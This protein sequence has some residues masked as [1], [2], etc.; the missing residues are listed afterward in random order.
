MGSLQAIVGAIRGVVLCTAADTAMLGTPRFRY[1]KVVALALPCQLVLGLRQKV[2]VTLPHSNGERPQLAASH[3][4]MQCR[5]PQASLARRAQP[6]CAPT[7]FVL[8]VMRSEGGDGS[9]GRTAA[10]AD[11]TSGRG[12]KQ[13]QGQEAR[14]TPSSKQA[15]EA[16]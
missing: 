16:K 4:Q 6:S 13:T 2:V 5:T 12:R 3:V 11:G 14:A 15:A 1:Y 8:I 9:A 7:R 10:L